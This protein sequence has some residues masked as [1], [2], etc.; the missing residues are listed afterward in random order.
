MEELAQGPS[1][2]KRM[3]TEVEHS[4]ALV[5]TF[6][7]ALL[8]SMFIKQGQFFPPR[9]S[10]P[11]ISQAPST[12]WP[13][14]A[15]ESERGQKGPGKCVSLCVCGEVR[16]GGSLLP[17]QVATTHGLESHDDIGDLQVSLLLQVGQD[18]G[19]KEDFALP[20]SVQVGVEFQGLDLQKEGHRFPFSA[21]PWGRGLSLFKVKPTAAPGSATRARE[22][23]G[24]ISGA[25]LGSP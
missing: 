17:G 6:P 1:A 8:T 9:K 2:N 14:R 19:P 25:G 11:S 5:S 3:R 4:R 12:P 18:P 16:A 24:W 7:P 15:R 23:C 13:L 10:C 22:V 20:D 21:M